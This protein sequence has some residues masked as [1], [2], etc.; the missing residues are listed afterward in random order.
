[1]QTYFL[2]RHAHAHNRSSWEG[3][4]TERPL[5]IKGLKQAQA[6][7]EYFLKQGIDEI[8]TSPAL[9]CIQSVQPLAQALKLKIIEDPSAL[10]AHPIELPLTDKTKKMVICAHGDN[11]PALL[12]SLGIYCDRCKK[13]SIWRVVLDEKAKVQEKEY[14]E[15]FL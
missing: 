8:R 13:A 15:P 4:D 7:V 12:N 9:R 11:I 10:E 3:Q 5:S 1:M 6:S 2:M 14:I